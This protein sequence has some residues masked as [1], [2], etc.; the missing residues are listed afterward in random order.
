MT[1]APLS[2]SG[3]PEPQSTATVVPE[4]MAWDSIARRLVTI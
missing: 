4:K 1:D 3:V 2:H